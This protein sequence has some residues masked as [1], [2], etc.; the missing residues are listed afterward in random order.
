MPLSGRKP[1]STEQG[2]HILNLRTVMLFVAVCATSAAF[3]ASRTHEQ[4]RIAFIASLVIGAILAWV[5]SWT[6][7]LSTT[8]FVRKCTAIFL[9]FLAYSFFISA[10]PALK[11]SDNEFYE[12][13]AWAPM[14]PEALSAPMAMFASLIGL[15]AIIPMLWLSTITETHNP[16]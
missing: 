12:S 10:I 7:T 14:P 4:I 2:F 16:E 15:C 13:G 3:F 11:L 5:I 9:L 6:T 8:Y 1:T